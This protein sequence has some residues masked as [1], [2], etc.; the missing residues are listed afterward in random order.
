M[1]ARVRLVPLL[2]L[3][4]A[5]VSCGK[6]GPPLAPLRLVP[7]APAAFAATRLGADVQ[8]RFTLPTKNIGG[9]GPLALD[10]V[11]V[12][13]VSLAP[14]APAPPNREFLTA[15][16]LVGTIDVKTPPE[17]G[18]AAEEAEADPRPAPGE[19]ATFVE[20]LTEAMLNPAAPDPPAPEAVPPV[21]PAAAPAAAAPAPAYPVRIYA[22][23]G[24]TRGG[25]PG[26]PTTR[27]SV[28]LV[29]PPAAPTAPDASF[30]AT[31]FV[32]SW[33]PPVA[34]VGTAPLRF[35]V[36]RAEA[37]SA[38]LNE[39]PV[40]GPTFEYPGVEFGTERCFSIRAITT[41]AEV[42]VASD[43]S[44]PVCVTPRDIFPPAAPTGLN[45]VSSP[46]VVALIWDANTEADLA[47]YLVL[48]GDAAGDTLQPLTPEP[49]TASVYRDTAV[50][51]GV[52]YAYVV[53]AIDRAT[54]P[55]RSAPS[56][57]VEVTA[58]Q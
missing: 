31:A 17:P 44:A 40:A 50:T 16:Y 55:N 45:G 8:L 6:K 24:I 18:A 39:A 36:Y 41:V 11:E 9:Q 13:A 19:V 43:A 12:Y 51:P 15:K 30:T 22:V 53:V 5:A 2:L 29:E 42:A 25:R 28:P 47:G 14:G 20:P 3:S 32:L 57:R 49:I 10:H 48:R 27:L 46:G 26:G 4:A 7:E 34:E 35:N 23:R 56:A 58:A 21:T 37:P 38:P 52:R 54:P 33:V 1:R